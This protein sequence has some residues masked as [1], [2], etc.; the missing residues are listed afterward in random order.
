MT[1]PITSK[2]SQNINNNNVKKEDTPFKGSTNTS[3]SVQED[4]LEIE[5]AIDVLQNL[6]NWTD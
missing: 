4:K 2:D 5:E 6:D 1:K 3:T